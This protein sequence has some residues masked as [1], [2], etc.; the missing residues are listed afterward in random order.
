MIR[1]PV[2]KLVVIT[3][4]AMSAG[5]SSAGV[6]EQTQRACREPA[7]SASYVARVDQALRSGQDVWGNELIAAPGGPTY[8]RVSRLLKPLLLAGAAK[9]TPLTES[10]VHYLAFTRPA[11]VQGAG[12]VALHVADGSQIVWRRVGGPT[13]SVGVGS[14][15]RE[16]YGSCLARL[17]P[18]GLSAGYLPILETRYVDANGVRYGQESF[19]ARLPETG[20]FASFVRLTADARGTG[21]AGTAIRFTAAQ[22]PPVQYAVPSDGVRTV[23]VA[24]PGRALTVDA[25]VYDAARR[26]VADYWERRLSEGAS[27]VVPEKRVLDATRNLLIQNLGLTW[28]YSIGNAYEQFSFPE[29]VDVAQVMAAYGFADVSRAIL[30]TSLNRRPTPYPNWKMGQKLVGSALHYRLFRNRSYVDQVT[31]VLRGYVQILGRQIAASPRGLLQRERYSSDIPDSVYGL[32]SQAIAWQGLRSMAWVWERTGRKSLAA[33]CRSLAA[34][35][36]AGLRQAVHASDAE[37]PDGSVFIPVQLLDGVEPYDA[38]TASRLGSYWNL[39]MPYALA[40]GFFAPGSREADGVLRYMLQHGSR[41]LGLVRAG[42]YA[43]YGKDAVSPAS[44]TDEVYGLNVARF[45]ADNDRPDQLVLSL[46][47]HLAAAM[48]PGTF[49]AGEAASIA[50][51]RSTYHR[52]MYLPPNGASNGSF[53]ERLRLML[54]HETIDG[55]G[56]PRGLE[57]AYAT[58]RAWLLPGRRIA[59]SRLPTSFGPISYSIAARSGS[60]RVT[61]DGPSRSRPA[62]LR[63]RLRLPRRSRITRVLLDGR[64]FPR[65]DPGTETIDLSGLPGSLDLDVGFGR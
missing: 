11:G 63:L 50:P 31:P 32:H 49:V 40:S 64:P 18:P 16:R 47:G 3:T 22:Q 17:A 6:A 28:R 5:A 65:F 43:L 54:V 39:V 41:F 29:G 59:V 60:I 35:L 51:I 27:I 44:G 34:R 1:W 9:Q 8:E 20:R 45:L 10:G 19:A 57:L 23:Y 2:A 58:P 61:I 33:R 37:L 30:R 7:L 4:L 42:A 21:A 62:A 12:A 14:G 24:W 46:Y 26:S 25:A 36:E 48:T 56:R 38:M 15:G 52:S 55:S 53:L 13:L